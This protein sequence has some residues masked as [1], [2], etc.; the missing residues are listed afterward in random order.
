[1]I[2]YDY[3]RSSDPTWNEKY[4]LSWGIKRTML[5]WF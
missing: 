1:M 2:K 5:Y 3:V 4:G